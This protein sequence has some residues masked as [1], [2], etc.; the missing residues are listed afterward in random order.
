MGYHY[1]RSLKPF[2]ALR[3]SSIPS[4][5][6][7]T[8]RLYPWTVK[9]QSGAVEA[10]LTWLWKLA[11]G[12]WRLIVSPGNSPS[13]RAGTSW[14]LGGLFYAWEA[15]SGIMELNHGYLEAHHRPLGGSLRIPLW[16][17]GIS[18]EPL[19][20][21]LEQLRL[22]RGDLPYIRWGV[23]LVPCRF[24]LESCGLHWNRAAYT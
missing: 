18:K 22:F 3:I 23:T 15:H 14:S 4:N 9:A 7:K 2:P 10:H 20:L 16:S 8:K 1:E 19:R 12:T 5:L 6:A 17:G 21:P 24:E 11:L 13:A